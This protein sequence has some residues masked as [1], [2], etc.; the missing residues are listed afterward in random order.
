MKKYVVPAM[1]MIT[2]S[3][4]EDVIRTSGMTTKAAGVGG[5]VS[6]NDFS[7]I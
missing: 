1:E 2:I 7:Q 5:S 6:N 3:A 4:T